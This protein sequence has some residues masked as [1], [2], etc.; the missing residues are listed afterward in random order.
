MTVTEIFQK[1]NLSPRGPVKWR[2]PVPESHKG[3][4]Y[5]VARVGNPNLRCT[6][7]GLRFKP[8]SGVRCDRVGVRIDRAYERDR[9][10]ESE[11]IVY[12]GQTK[13]G[14]RK[15]VGQFYAQQPGDPGPHAGGQIALL[16]A[17]GL[18]VYWS[19]ADNPLSSE[20]IMLDAFE[21]QVGR[22]P[23]ANSEPRP[24]RIRL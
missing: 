19:S 9:W 17:C 24:K 23:F 21:K 13:Q 14:I 4:V 1:A 12:I 10:L 11:P 20:Q 3:G 18:W 7:C 22:L 5:V 2:E 6:A 16:L 8:L 15:R